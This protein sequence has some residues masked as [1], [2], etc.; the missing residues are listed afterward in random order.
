MKLKALKTLIPKAPKAPKVKGKTGIDLSFMAYLQNI[1]LSTLS[2]LFIGFALINTSLFFTDNVIA[3][4]KVIFV[5]ILLYLVFSDL[6]DLFIDEKIFKTPI[7]T[8][9]LTVGTFVILSILPI[10]VSEFAPSFTHWVAGAIYSIF[11]VGFI[12]TKVFVVTVPSK[13]GIVLSSIAFALFHTLVYSS[14]MTG[15]GL[16]SSLIFAFLANIVFN[17]IFINSKSVYLVMLLHGV[18]NMAKWG[19]LMMLVV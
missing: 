18:F 19:I 11:V 4:Q 9:L 2:V 5:Y 15:I 1:N 14:Q 12:E 13:I 10:T 3:W 7:Q 17:I 16:F 8:G 6:T